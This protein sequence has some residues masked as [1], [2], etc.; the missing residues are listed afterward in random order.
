MV[1]GEACA[2]RQ[3]YAPRGAVDGLR[4]RG[5]EID[6]V[7]G[8]EGGGAQLQMLGIGLALEIGL[9]ERR[10]LIG[11][12]RLLADQ[13]DPLRIAGLTQRGGKLVA[14]LPAADDHH[15][16]APAACSVMPTSRSR[17]A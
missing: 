12:A 10:A 7:V 3:L 5:D 17:S 4:P 1:V 6:A 16:V 14:A 2:V 9:G 11:Q 15:A 13:R 8:I